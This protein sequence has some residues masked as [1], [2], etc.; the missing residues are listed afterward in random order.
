MR[1]QQFSQAFRRR[2]EGEIKD[3][4]SLG[5]VDSAVSFWDMEIVALIEDGELP[6]SAR[7]WEPPGWLVNLE[8]KL[9]QRVQ[10]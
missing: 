1:K 7:N 2:W 9:L 6:P 3:Q 4:I 5:Q 10:E 8:K